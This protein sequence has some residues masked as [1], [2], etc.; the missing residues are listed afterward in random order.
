MGHLNGC[1]TSPKL[2]ELDDYFFIIQDNISD[3][4]ISKTYADRLSHLAGAILA[5]APKG[6]RTLIV[7]Q[8]AIQESYFKL[9]MVL[10]ELAST[11]SIFQNNPKIRGGDVTDTS[12]SDA[13]FPISEV[14]NILSLDCDHLFMNDDNL[15][16]VNLARRLRRKIQLRGFDNYPKRPNLMYGGAQRLI[17]YN[18]LKMSKSNSNT[19]P[20]GISNA[21]LVSEVE[22]LSNRRWLYKKGSEFRWSFKRGDTSI[23]HPEDYPI[24]TFYKAF[25]DPYALPIAVV[26]ASEQY[27]QPVLKQ[28]TKYNQ[29]VLDYFHSDDFSPE[30]IMMRLRDD[31]AVA[32]GI[33]K[34]NVE[35]Y[36]Q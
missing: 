21:G 12:V 36:L 20:L 8:S 19:I 30:R 6:P 4:N 3:R 7:R 16:F 33:I 2:S 32:S 11:N 5:L 9:Y 28:V 26:G 25:V 34:E 18:Y 29:E 23:L 10:C 14:C 24:F 31:E 22:R 27:T 35:W 1:L 13:I 15:R 17:G